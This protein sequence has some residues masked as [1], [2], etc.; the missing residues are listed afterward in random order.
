MDNLK[1]N[2]NVKKSELEQAL[3]LDNKK[4]G[5]YKRRNVLVVII[6]LICTVGIYYII[7][8]PT[9]FIG[10]IV[11]VLSILCIVF[12]FFYQNY[13][14]KKYINKMSN[15]WT[16]FNLSVDENAIHICD[17][18]QLD[19]D[20]RYYDMDFDGNLVVYETNKL[21]VYIYKG[22]TIFLTPKR[23]LTLEQIV[24]LHDIYEENA[25]DNYFELDNLTG[26][27]IK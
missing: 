27:R 16:N 24:R 13:N 18:T 14:D 5:V 26:K 21:F 3:N 12:L 1:L 8:S 22:K 17:P 9:A 2:Y 25:K 23:V 15:N 19:N 20:K 4:S 11:S 7:K 10:Y 6:S